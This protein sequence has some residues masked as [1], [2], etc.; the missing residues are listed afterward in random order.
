MTFVWVL[1]SCFIC[2]FI[3]SFIS[4]FFF[5][6]L[7]FFFLLLLK[8]VL[9][10]LVFFWYVRI[11]VFRSAILVADITLLAILST[12]NA[13]KFIKFLNWNFISFISWFEY[14][15]PMHAPAVSNKWRHPNDV[16]T[17]SR[18]V[19]KRH[20][21]FFYFWRTYTSKINNEYTWKYINKHHVGKKSSITRMH[22]SN[23]CL[24]PNI[25][26][27]MKYA[28]TDYVR[29]RLSYFTTIL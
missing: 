16:I 28:I 8:F 11:E 26:Q 7:S 9:F 13:W 22:V 20:W 27:W 14:S 17:S 19:T 5:L 12:V 23:M 6:F 18:R 15:T 24:W 25:T 2:L 21:Y 1:F 3:Y 29:I 10:V 4:L